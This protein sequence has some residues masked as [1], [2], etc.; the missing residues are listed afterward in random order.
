MAE[1]DQALTSNLQVIWMNKTTASVLATWVIACTTQAEEVLLLELISS[2]HLKLATSH[3][4]LNTDN[5]D[6]IPNNYIL[7]S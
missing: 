1:A 3:L 2:L 7:N 4:D 5:N 6:C